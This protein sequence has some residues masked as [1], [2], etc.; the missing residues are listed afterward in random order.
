MPV[1]DDDASGITGIYQGFAEAKGTVTRPGPAARARCAEP[2]HDDPQPK[3]N[4][5]ND[6]FYSGTSMKDPDVNVTTSP[7]IDVHRCIACCLDFSRARGALPKV[8]YLCK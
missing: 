6:L 5:Q 4:I 3:L 2:E 1:R 8:V 7:P